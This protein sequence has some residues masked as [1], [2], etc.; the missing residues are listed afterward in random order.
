MLGLSI[1][2]GPIVIISG[3]SVTA[4]KVYRPQLWLGWVLFIVGM[5]CF[6][7]VDADSPLAQG[8]GWPVLMG[9]GAGIL[10]G[11]SVPTPHILFV[12]D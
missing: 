10:Y 8:V 6:T 4:L 12:Q 3:V 9:A 11:A 7:T 2:M 5:G 1:S